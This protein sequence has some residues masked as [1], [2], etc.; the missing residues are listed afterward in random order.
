MKLQLQKPDWVY[1]NGSIRPWKEA[2]LHVS[3]EAVN[4][5]LSVFEGIRCYTQENN[6]HLGLLALP[7][8]YARLQESARML[9]IPFG[10]SY[11]EFEAACHQ[12]LKKLRQPENDMW[13]RATLYVIDGHW[14]EGTAADLVLTCYQQSKE[15][16]KPIKVGVTTWR[17]SSDLSLPPRIKS[18]ANYQVARLARIE[19]RSRGY[20]EMLL[21]NGFGRIAEAS[22]SG[23]IMVRDGIVHS[24]PPSEGALESITVRIIR[25]LCESM[26]IPFEFRPIDRTEL[27]VAQELALAGTLSEITPIESVDDFRFPQKWPILEKIISRF[28]AA[29]RGRDPHPAIDLS[30]AAA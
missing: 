2:V 15:P 5:G 9:H 13:I 12:L 17:R 16:P 21:L 27:Y 29:T 20:S 11:A 14:G 23:V 28:Q 26:S 7:R 4:R 22:G 30:L 3:T 8:H 6:L 1:F 18:A 24:P 19:G 25:S 10:T